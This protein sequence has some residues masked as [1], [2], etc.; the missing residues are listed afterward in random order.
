MIER[1]RGVHPASDFPNSYKEIWEF[2]SSWKLKEW[3]D[4]CDVHVR[5]I[6]RGIVIGGDHVFTELYHKLHR[7][8]LYFCK[9]SVGQYTRDPRG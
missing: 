1:A 8:A 7:A 2:N 6:M 3:V 5:T 4:W 9:S